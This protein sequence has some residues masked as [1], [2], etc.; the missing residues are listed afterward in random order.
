MALNPGQTSG[1]EED[2]RNILK[3]QY[4]G[5]PSSGAVRYLA[6]GDTGYSPGDAQRYGLPM[7]QS[8]LAEE[9]SRLRSE[10]VKPAIDSLEASRGEVS[11]KYATASSQLEAEKQPMIDRYAKLLG[12]IT[13]RITKDTTTNFAQRGFDTQSGF[14][15]E[16][17]TNKVNPAQQDITF[18]RE[19]KLRG[20]GNT[21]ANL[22]N[23]EVEQLRKITTT[24]A[25]LKANGANQAITDALTLYQ[26]QKSQE[27]QLKIAEIQK[28]Q[29]TTPEYKTVEF[30]NNLYS[31]N[32]ADPNSLKTLAAKAGGGASGGGIQKYLGPQAQENLKAFGFIPDNR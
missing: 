26:N 8:M 14:I 17:I 4:G 20:I 27:L 25:E 24:I 7:S 12:D 19:D 28:T 10:A 2:A 31:F 16:A 32:P 9:Q 13:G 5:E 29:P 21:Q 23:D 30:G 1:N 22:V 3:S 15:Q 6:H 18:E 11:Q